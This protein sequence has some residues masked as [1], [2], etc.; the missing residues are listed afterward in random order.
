MV[1]APR[2]SVR[3]HNFVP[4]SSI[5]ISHVISGDTIIIWSP[6]DSSG[7]VVRSLAATLRWRVIRGMVLDCHVVTPHSGELV[8]V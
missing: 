4:I 7:V 5:P 1:P 3:S 6:H 8:A 2:N